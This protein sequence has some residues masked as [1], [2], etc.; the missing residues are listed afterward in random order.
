MEGGGICAG[1]SSSTPTYA[2][3]P[4]EICG[5]N[6]NWGETELEVWRLATPKAYVCQSGKCVPGAGGLPLADCEQTCSP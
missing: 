3:G 5:G 1:D 2:G 4:N 6:H